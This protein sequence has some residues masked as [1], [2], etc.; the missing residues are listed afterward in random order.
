MRKTLIISILSIVYIPLF[1]VPAYRGPYKITQADGSEKTVYVHGDEHFHYMTDAEGTWLKW[2]DNKLVSAEALSA[3]EIVSRREASPMRV[4]QRKREA[5]NDI[6]LAP[7]GLVILVNFSNLSFAESNTRE[8]FDRMMNE[9]DYTYQGATGSVKDY[10][11]AQSFGMYDPIF[12][13]VGPVTLNNTYQYYGKNDSYYDQDSRPDQMI[14]DAC[15]K[16]DSELGV[17][18]SQYDNDNDGFVDFVFVFYA[19]HGEADYYYADTDVI[20]PHM[21]YVYYNGYGTTCRLDG[22]IIDQ[23]ACSNELPYSSTDARPYHVGIS[24]CCHEFSHVMGLPDMYNTQNPSDILT[25]GNWDIMDAGPHNNNGRTPP[26][27]SGYERFYCGFST[28]RILNSPC[29]VTLSD[30]KSTGQILLITSTGAH[31]LNGEK[32]NPSTFYVLENH[33]KTGWDAFLPGHGL[34][35]TRVKYNTLAWQNNTVN[36]DSANHRI[37]LIPADGKISFTSYSGKVGDGGDTYP[38][39]KN[40]TT[41]TLLNDYP[42]TDITEKDGQIHFKFMGGGEELELSTS[43]IDGSNLLFSTQSETLNIS[44]LTEKQHIAVYNAVGQ[45]IQ[46]TTAQSETINIPLQK[47]IYIVKVDNLIKK[48]IVN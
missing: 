33:Q 30:I 3:D 7:R 11:R 16:A 10:F 25:M 36:N 20:W 43:T 45:L 2:Q 32:P 12:D 40:V 47:G 8:E 39:T 27:Y 17:D 41:C 6:N 13:V 22:K 31:N 42:I 18:F 23:Y 38:G 15:K 28:P 21:S 9:P 44:G 34:L 24:T 14:I 5:A 1:A 4:M 29:N 26:A 19:G 48:I 35:V 46:N 37:A